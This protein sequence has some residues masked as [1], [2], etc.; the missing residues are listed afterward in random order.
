MNIFKM[1]EK[2]RKEAINN[3]LDNISSEQLLIELIK[4]GLEVKNL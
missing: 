4:E 3:L 2:E 1:N